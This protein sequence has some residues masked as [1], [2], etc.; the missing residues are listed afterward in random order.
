MIFRQ[1]HPYGFKHFHRALEV[2][3][4]ATLSFIYQQTWRCIIYIIWLEMNS[5]HLCW[6]QYGKKRLWNKNKL[7]ESLGRILFPL[8]WN[9][10]WSSWCWFSSGCDIFWKDWSQPWTPTQNHPNWSKWSLKM[11]DHW[12][13]ISNL[14]HIGFAGASIPSN[15]H[16]YPWLVPIT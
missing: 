3:E 13:I 10:H 2:I 15:L 11:Y 7:Q 16:P 9:Y 1:W 14:I 8:C 5:K 12:F 6:S 4:I